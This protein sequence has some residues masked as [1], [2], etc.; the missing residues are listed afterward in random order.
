VTNL[1]HQH[2]A[3]PDPIDLLSHHAYYQLVHT[4]FAVLPPPLADTPEAMIARNDAA[5]AKV[6]ALAPVG[7]DEADIA[8]HCIAARAQGEDVLRL[9]RIHAGDIQIVMKL[10][11]QY[12]LMERTAVSIRAQL[13]RLQAAR[14]KREPDSNPATADELA[15]YIAARMMRQA[16]D[17]GLARGVPVSDNP[18][19]P[20]SGEPPPIPVFAA[21]PPAPAPVPQPPQARVL[22]A[23]PPSTPP[24]PGAIPAA[25]PV[26]IPATPPLPVA[27]QAALADAPPPPPAPASDAAP[28]RRH[29]ARPTT[30][31]GEPPR[32]LP[33]EAD[34]YAIMYPDRVR[35]IRRYGGLPPDCTF[36][37][38]DDDLVHAIVTGTS[39]V[40]R[41][42]D[43]P[44]AAIA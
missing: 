26:A 21:P 1:E 36:G 13:Q 38:P 2:Q 14:R 40:L 25:L 28:S 11:A 8:A 32:D 4:L 15:R 39:L 42:L 5:I 41:A 22:A 6:A 24:L 19:P 9:I 29:R 7:A 23:G 17:Q 30:W 12:A 10:H 44:V 35:L 3:D 33:A 16:L 27:I 18:V 43:G 34:Y 20:L 37:P 31:A